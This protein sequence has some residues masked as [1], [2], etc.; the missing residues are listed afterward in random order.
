MKTICGPIDKARGLGFRPSPIL[1]CPLCCARTLGTA[2]IT[3]GNRQS[4][5][6]KKNPRI[7]KIGVTNSLYFTYKRRVQ[8]Q[9]KNII[10]SGFHIAQ[11]PVPLPD[12]PLNALY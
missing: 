7:T 12:S 8:C 3:P 5:A 6:N 10:I 11:I 2:I 1:S 4:A 9:T